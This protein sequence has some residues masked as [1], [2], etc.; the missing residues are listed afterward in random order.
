MKKTAELIAEL[1]SVRILACWRMIARWSSAEPHSVG[2]QRTLELSS[3]EPLKRTVRL[4]SA[5][6]L[7]QWSWRT[8]GPRSG[9]RCLKLKSAAEQCSAGLSA[10]AVVVVWLELGGRKSV[11]Q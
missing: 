7:E 2:S 10:A 4:N 5:E 3:V 1:S 9:K 8:A 11:P 6:L